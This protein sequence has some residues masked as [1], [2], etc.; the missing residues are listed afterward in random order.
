[1]K[2]EHPILFSTP[3]VQALLEGRKTMTRRICKLQPGEG[4]YYEQLA[5]DDWAYISLGGMSGPY[6]CPYG[7]IGDT[8]WVRETWAWHDDLIGSGWYIHKSI[9][10]KDYPGQKWKPSIFMPKEACRMKLEITNIRVERLQ[11]ISEEDA[12]AEGAIP[13]KQNFDD[14]DDCWTD[15]K[16]KTAYEYLW[17][18]INGWDPNSWNENKFVW[19]IEFKNISA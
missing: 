14:S 18:E 17:N 9:N 19:V 1:M 2:K 16:H 4:E 13:F 12:K 8:I 11:D 5:E 7:K 10:E 3:M 6:R 15:G